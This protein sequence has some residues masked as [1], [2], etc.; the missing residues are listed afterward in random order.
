M[1]DTTTGRPVQDGEKIDPKRVVTFDPNTQRYDHETKSVQPRTQVTPRTLGE[2]IAELE[3]RVAKLEAQ[4][5][6]QKNGQ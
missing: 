2:R 3:A 5:V 6:A 4:K 1:I